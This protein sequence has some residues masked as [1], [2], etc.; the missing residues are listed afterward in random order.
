MNSSP[1]D[2]IADRYDAWFETPVGSWAGQREDEAIDA[3]LPLH[4][5]D[6]LL[7]IGAGTGRHAASLAMRG[8][9]VIAIDPSAQMLAR[10]AERASGLDI[11][12]VR[13][14]AARLPFGAGQFD[15]AV[16]ITSL[17]FASDPHAVL[18]E[19][20]RVIEPGGYLL[21]GELNRASLWTTLRR[22]K[23]RFR[24]STY[25][26]AR[27]HTAR[28]LDAL[29]R[30]AGFDSVAMTGVLHLPPISSPRLLSA[31]SPIE[32]LAS[33]LAPR[34]GA[35]VV[36]VGKLPGDAAPGTVQG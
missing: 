7:D 22:I 25:R 32:R 28:E 20:A 14:D 15:G 33:R 29:L 9:R 11:Q 27:F 30:V 2:T 8:A 19:A 24:P 17:C 5:G 4:A 18:R 31:L 35:F 6:L 34:L 26:S 12:L 3:L 1:F 16:A 13:A 10:A 36:V 21:L 23:A